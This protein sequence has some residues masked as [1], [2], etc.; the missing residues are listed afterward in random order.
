MICDFI[1]MHQ[2]IKIATSY[3]T[4]IVTFLEEGEN[5]RAEMRGIHT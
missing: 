4:R 3:S 5:E 1:F 2:E